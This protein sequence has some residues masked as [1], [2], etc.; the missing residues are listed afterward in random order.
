MRRKKRERVSANAPTHV[1]ATV[2]PTT[3]DPPSATVLALPRKPK[4]SPTPAAVT[5]CDAGV[6]CKKVWSRWWHEGENIAL[7][8]LVC[9]R[10]SLLEDAR[11]TGQRLRLQFRRCWKTRYRSKR[12]SQ[13]LRRHLP[14]RGFLVRVRV[15][16]GLLG[17][18]LWRGFFGAFGCWCWCGVW[19]RVHG[20]ERTLTHYP[21]CQSAS[22]QQ[23]GRAVLS[24]QGP[25][26]RLPARRSQ[27][28]TWKLETSS[29]KLK[30]K[31]ACLDISRSQGGDAPR[32]LL[33]P[34]P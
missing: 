9:A 20:R 16:L 28:T 25:A 2:K 11:G 3:T 1:A 31:L 10:A 8:E 21:A 5:A 34:H 32:L 18:H 29:W 26:T 24:L 6:G 14:R 22:N 17:C 30:F 7:I 27:L 33:P 13:R 23:R 12:L 19:A 4:P 15:E